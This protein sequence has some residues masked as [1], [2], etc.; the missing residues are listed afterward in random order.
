MHH[1]LY[2]SQFHATMLNCTIQNAHSLKAWKRSEFINIRQQKLQR[3]CL[4]LQ[5]YQFFPAAIFH[6]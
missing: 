6:H 5:R 1:E 4:T 2:L 3:Y